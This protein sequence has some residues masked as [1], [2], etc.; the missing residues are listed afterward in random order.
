M[1]FGNH[2]KDSFIC[3]VF[4]ETFMLCISNFSIKYKYDI[5]KGSCIF[6]STIRR[7]NNIS[8]K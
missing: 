8:I 1:S 4:H 5:I 7:K 3:H 6:L 2:L